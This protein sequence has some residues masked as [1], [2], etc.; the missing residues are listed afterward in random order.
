MLSGDSKKGINLG[1][2]PKDRFQILVVEF[3][4]R[5]GMC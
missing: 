2:V 4:V 5:E 3:T 1:T